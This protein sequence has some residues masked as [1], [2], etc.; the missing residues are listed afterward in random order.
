MKKEG[1]DAIDDASV[2]THRRLI[3][4]LA[5]SSGIPVIYSHIGFVEV[6]VGGL[7][8]RANDLARPIRESAVFGSG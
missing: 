1:V 6:E 8:A 4:D 7:M 5:A 3:V 2:F